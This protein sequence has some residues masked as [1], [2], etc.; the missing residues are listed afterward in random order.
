MGTSWEVPSSPE[1]YPWLKELQIPGN[2][3]IFDVW[4][5]NLASKVQA[6]LD[7]NIIDW[8]VAK[9]LGL[10]M[11]TNPPE[12]SYSGLAFGRPNRRRS[13]TALS[14]DV[15]INVALKRKRLL[16]QYG[17]MSSYVSQ[18]SSNP[19]VPSSLNPPTTLTYC[20]PP[21]ALHCHA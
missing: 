8:L 20:N 7:R 15:A 14:Y 17:I 6:I 19:S 3:E 16:G 9:L 5:D 1:A 18:T 21:R 4:E 2:H 12:T 10:A 11:S 13:S